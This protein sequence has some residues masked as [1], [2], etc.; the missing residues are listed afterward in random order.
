MA[1]TKYTDTD[2]NALFKQHYFSLADNVY[3]T[4]SNLYSMVPKTYN[5][6]GN[7]GEHP[8]GV[9]FGGSVSSGSLPTAK[10]RRYIKPTYARKRLYG[11]LD[12]DTETIQASDG[13]DSFKKATEEQ[14]LG[15]IKSF[16]R[17]MARIFMNDGTGI[18]GQHSGNFT[19]TAADPIATIIDTI[20]ST[21]GFVPAYF[22]VGDTVKINSLTSEFEIVAVSDTAKTATLERKTGSD[23]L[24]AIGAGTHSIY[25]ANS[26]DADPTGALSLT[27]GT[28]HG[29]PAERRWQLGANL[30]GASAGITPDLVNRLVEDI[31]TACD[32][33]PTHL[34]FSPVQYRKYLNLM[35]D[36][37]RYPQNTVLKPRG[38]SRTSSAAIAKS[39]IGFSGIEYVSSQGVIPVLKNK[40]IRPNQLWAFNMDM[41]EAAHAAAF[42]WFDKDGS[43]LHMRENDDAYYARYGGFMEI[44]WNP[45]SQG[46]VH[47]LAV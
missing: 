16:N 39:T 32:E 34:A 5:F 27:G 19:G 21:Y 40:M 41:V 47:T 4:F 46:R 24:T 37:K 13:S 26:R 8:V 1:I 38:N 28:I 30:D 31:D 35:E 15:V 43:I 3:S 23:D 22:E 7:T 6:K 45:L 17:N 36:L 42:G 12:L 25:L 29:V 18:L 10:S 33:A 44:K 9:T 20:G 2:Y 11:V 14:T